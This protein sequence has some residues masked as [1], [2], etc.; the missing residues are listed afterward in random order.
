M[1]APASTLVL[2]RR[3][4]RAL[5]RADRGRAILAQPIYPAAASKNGAKTMSLKPLEGFKPLMTQHCITGSMRHVYLYNDFPVS[6]ELLLGLGA[7]VGFIYWHQ[8]GAPPFMGGRA[9][10]GQG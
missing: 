1:G 8:K 7:G 10:H 2:C 9:G 4:V 5:D 3:H 6:E